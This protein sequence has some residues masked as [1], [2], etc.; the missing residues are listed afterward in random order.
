MAAVEFGLM[1]R[2]N[3]PGHPLQTVLD[4]NHQCIDA[5]TAGFSTLWLEDH[6][7]VG[8][9]DELECLTTLSYLAAQ[10]PQFNV[11]SMVLS[12]S[13]RNPALLAKMAAN[14]QFLTRGRL[15]LGL[16]AG[17]KEDEYH[18][19]NYPFPS[20]RI[21]MEQLEETIHVLR[22]M[23]GTQPATFEG[24]HYQVHEAY[25]APRPE[26]VIPLVVGGG[27]EQRTLAI[28]A[29]YAD[30]W[31]FNSCT[32][33]EYGRKLSILKQHC[34]R[35]GRDPSEIKLS[36]LSTLSV[37]EQPEQVKRNP[38]KHFIAG[39]AAEVMRELEQFQA[40]GV[41]HFMFRILD[42][43]SLKHFVNAVV[44]HF[45]TSQQS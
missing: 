26:T 8:A 18:A 27:G 15:I 2:Q 12:Q 33:E 4:F 10:Y 30:W 14:L 42:V 9:T 21:R 3:D 37:S 39:S 5:L 38:N 6:L 17:W 25:C 36:Y 16:G 43:E 44:P 40:I 45:V 11:G 32:V 7:Q 35:V 34:E 24:Q 29:R 19:Y 20:T 41:S 23:W 13:Y 1:L 28:V 22:A 31:N